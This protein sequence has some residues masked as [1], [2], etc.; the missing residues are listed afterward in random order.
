VSNEF[1]KSE[2]LPRRL[3]SF[4]DGQMQKRLLLVETTESQIL[5][6]RADADEQ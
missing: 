2:L 6:K 4:I 1:S 5:G 3:A